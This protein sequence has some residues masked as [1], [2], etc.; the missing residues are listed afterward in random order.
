MIGSSCS[1]FS[2]FYR[3]AACRCHSQYEGPHCE[4]HKNSTTTA[5][6]GN[7]GLFESSNQ[8]SGRSGGAK[9]GI[10]ITVFLC[11]GVIGAAY[12][13]YQKR[14]LDVTD[15]NTNIA[16]VY[17]DME[18]SLALDDQSLR[19]GPIVDVGPEKDY[20]GNELKNVELL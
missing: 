13:V 4:Y 19:A 3:G 18:G 12:Y 2:S 6:K 8:K 20:D 15:E 17:P 11:L 9:F 16:P 10:A 5:A 14:K 7:H 1:Y